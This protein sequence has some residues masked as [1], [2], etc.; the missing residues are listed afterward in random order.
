VVTTSQKAAPARLPKCAQFCGRARKS[1]FDGSGVRAALAA[2]VSALPVD[3]VFDR[4]AA[5]SSRT[6]ASTGRPPQRVPGWGG[7]LAAVNRRPRRLLKPGSK[8][9]GPAPP[10]CGHRVRFPLG[11][12]GVPGPRWHNSEPNNSKGNNKGTAASSSAPG[13]AGRSDPTS[14]DALCERAPAA[15][16]T[17]SSSP[18]GSATTPSHP[19]PSPALDA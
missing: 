19:L 2:S 4:A 10:T 18:A 1:A 9:R 5:S 16:A 11:T 8:Q 15:A 17:T 13:D 6:T 12:N 7:D 14:T 3:E